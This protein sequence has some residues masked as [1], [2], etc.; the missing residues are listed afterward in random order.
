MRI[1]GEAWLQFDVVA[2]PKG[3]SVLRQT[4]IFLPRG[5][6]GR[7]Y[8]Y[9]LGPVHERV[10]AGMLR[11]IARAVDRSDRSRSDLVE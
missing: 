5:V 10:F 9:L 6:L 3:G 7:L 1:P 2:D 11:G 8:W 4:A